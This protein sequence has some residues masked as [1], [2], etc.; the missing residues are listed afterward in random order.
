[1]CIRDSSNSSF[2]A[3]LLHEMGHSTAPALDRQMTGD[4]RSK[5]YAHEEIVAELSSIFSSV[6]LAVKAETDPEAAGY[7]A[8]S[9]T[10]LDTADYIYDGFR[11]ISMRSFPI[12][13][14]VA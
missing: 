9:Y 7:G 10:H 4:M 5:E 13:P 11:Y 12:L 3:S 1:M 6:D 2:L 8:V 14:I